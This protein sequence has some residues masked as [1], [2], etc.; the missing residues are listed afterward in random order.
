MSLKPE[1]VCE[2]CGA[3]GATETAHI[4]SRGA[5]GGDEWWNLLELCAFCHRLGGKKSQHGWG[6]GSMIERRPF[7]RKALKVRGWE[8]EWF[9]GKFLMRRKA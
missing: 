7:L 9:H 3:S 5:G 1:G 2:S 8:W 4:K 6:W